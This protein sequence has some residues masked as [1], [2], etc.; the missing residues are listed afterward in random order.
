MAG[1]ALDSWLDAISGRLDATIGEVTDALGLPGAGLGNDR[2]MLRQILRRLTGDQMETISIATGVAADTVFNLT[3][4]RFEPILP[5]TTEPHQRAAIWRVV[6]GSRHCP[7]CLSD[8]GGRWQL[9]WR[10][11]WVFACTTHHCLLADTCP[12]CHRRPRSRL[13]ALTTVATPTRC[14][15]P[16]PRS[17]LRRA[18]GQRTCGAELAA[19]TAHQLTVDDTALGAQRT[20]NELLLEHPAQAI[21]LGVPVSVKDLFVDLAVIARHAL[22]ARDPSGDDGP[23]TA[24]QTAQ[25]V[26]AAIDVIGAATLDEAASRLALLLPDRPIRRSGANYS[27]LPATWRTASPRLQQA[28]LKARHPYLR[29]ADQLRFATSLPRP[30]QRVMGDRSNGRHHKVPQAFW[31]TWSLRLMPTVGHDATSYGSVLAACIMLPGSRL[32][33]RDAAASLGG[34][35]TGTHMTHVLN[36]L[37]RDGHADTVMAAIADI[38][39]RLDATTVPIDYQRRRQIFIGHQLDTLPQQAWDQLCDQTGTRKGTPGHHQHARRYLIEMLTGNSLTG[40]PTALEFND[41]P[42]RASYHRFYCT[43]TQTM[44]ALLRE[45]AQVLL[46]ACRIHE[47]VTWEPPPEWLCPDVTY[48]GPLPESIDHERLVDLVVTRCLS[49]KRAAQE[50]GTTIDHVRLAIR[51]RPVRPEPS[52]EL[53]AAPNTKHAQTGPLSPDRIRHRYEQCHWTWTQIA[54]EA[55]CSKHTA[56]TIGKSAGITSRTGHRR[57]LQVDP[58]WLRHEYLIER[59]T[60]PD[61]A[62]EL[63]SSPTAVARV[64]KDLGVPLR[65]RGAA[66]HTAALSPHRRPS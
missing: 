60:L 46:R 40:L 27:V 64:A 31:P 7:G 17:D 34:G 6:P 38:T 2:T 12:G 14:Q 10:L 59:R 43:L 4:T 55:G 3:L 37:L 53:R 18:A 16:V 1:E 26:T 32:T 49:T 52:P 24:G 51:L 48:P 65:A 22:P 15:Q 58:A 25:A 13:P 47:P 42:E 9:A 30:S 33:L 63:H 45:H 57:G 62:A 20:L 23:L 8:T 11:P 41:S 61:L 35:T 28:V 29:P 39:D 56:M 66:S 36:G 44:A 54:T 50:L 5:R 19:S 21:S